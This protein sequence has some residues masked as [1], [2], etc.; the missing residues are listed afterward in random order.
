MAAKDR[1]RGKA[2]ERWVAAKL[3]ARRRRAGEGLAHDDIVEESGFA[4]PISLECKTYAQLQLRQDWIDQAKRNAGARP[5][6][7]VQR[8]RGSQGVYV[9]IDFEFFLAL[10]KAWGW[11]T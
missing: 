1:A 7:V 6:A 10:L 5:W 11:E 2:F 4:L 8:P 9:T 3:G